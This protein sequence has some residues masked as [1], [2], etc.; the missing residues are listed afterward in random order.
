MAE[1]QNRRGREFSRPW[2]P[3]VHPT[4]HQFTPYHQE[5]KSNSSNVITITALQRDK[6]RNTNFI[7]LDGSESKSCARVHAHE[8]FIY[9]TNVKRLP[10]DRIVHVT[11]LHLN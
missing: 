1:T 4:S 11:M 3:K 8:I 7:E 10:L 2:F 5:T 9:N 6:E